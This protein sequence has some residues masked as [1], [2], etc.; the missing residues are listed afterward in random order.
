MKPKVH[1]NSHDY[2][3]S[4]SFSDAFGLRTS[5]D[6][7]KIGNGHKYNALDVLRYKYTVPGGRSNRFLLQHPGLKNQVNALNTSVT[8]KKGGVVKA[9]NGTITPYYNPNPINE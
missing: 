8:L 7:N 3:L 4:E 6:V 2:E 5:M 1:V 9:Q